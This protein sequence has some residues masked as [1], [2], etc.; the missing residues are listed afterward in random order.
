MKLLLPK[1]NAIKIIEDRIAGIHE[2][3]FNAEAWKERTVLDLKEIFPPGSMQFLK[4]EF[5]RFDTYIEANK[6]KVMTDTK[7]N[8]EEILKSYVE[9]IKEH[10]K[11]AEE[12]K[13]ITEKDFEDKY[14]ELLKD[15]N[16][17][18]PDYKKIVNDYSR[19]MDLTNELLDKTE[20]LTNQIE[21][22][23]K[24][25]IQI[26]DISFSQISKVFFKLPILRIITVFSIFGA[27]IVSVFGLG[28]WYKEILDNNQIY[29]YK[30]ENTGFK[31]AKV[32]Y[33]KRIIN[34]EL[35]N[36]ELSQKVK[37]IKP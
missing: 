21:I 20:N 35:E 13:A 10:S 12:K 26:E 14:Y 15:W 6:T 2:L 17:L 37:T 1:E 4:I 5:L 9:Y 25:T 18:V 33:E 28:S 32:E 7:H 19:E 30:V 34:L 3:N 29:E 36:K 31:K 8:A 11:V 22:L 27:V 24:E 16:E 23:K